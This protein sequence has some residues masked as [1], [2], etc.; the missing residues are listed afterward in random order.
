MDLGLKYFYKDKNDNSAIYQQYLRR[1]EKRIK[2]RSR[3]LSR[4]FVRGK[5]QSNNYHKARIQLGRATL[6]VQRQ[7]KDWA[8]KL[9]GVRS[10]IITMSWWDENL[11]IHNLVKNHHDC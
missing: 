3:Q 2:K 6:K 8:V 7:C 4:K 9:A 10:G 5:P 1:S 11:N